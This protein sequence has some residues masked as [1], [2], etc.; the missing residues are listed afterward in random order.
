MAALALAACAPAAVPSP[1]LTPQPEAAPTTDV[2]RLTATPS[3]ASLPPAERPAGR[4]APA[5]PDAQVTP[6]P[7][8][9][10]ATPNPLAAWSI[11]AL[12]ARAYG[13]GDILVREDSP[14]L[15]PFHR[16]VIEYPSDGIT[17]T[18]LLEAPYGDG[19]FPVIVVLH[20]YIPVTEYRRGDDALAAADH[21]AMQ[22]YAVLI[23]D[24]RGYM[25]TAGGP[26]PLRIPYAVDALNLIESLDT[27][28][29]LDA[30]RVGVIG[31]SMGGGAAS[32]VMVL[33]ERVDAVV[34]YAPMSA[35]QALNY[36]YIAE[37]WS[38]YWMSLTAARYG[39]PESNPAGYAATS[40]IN[41]LDRVR[42][43]VQIHHGTADGEVPYA[44]SADLAARLEAAG[45]PVELFSYPGAGHT[46]NGEDWPR[47]LARV[48]A[49]F[50]ANVREDQP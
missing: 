46:F 19:P 7:V 28:D 29:V 13:E 37:E 20:G 16:Y 43:P 25:G 4:A 38:A 23:P 40:P 32:Y 41:A 12:A 6:S 27:L 21:F 31:H 17:V 45:A 1:S 22:G 39:S 42:A 33:S 18:G 30:D 9:P 14:E 15:L 35:D 50:A 2:A 34:L 11:P 10:T 5:D 24:Y 44:W 47:F 3:P 36:T 26:D 8:L 48:E 49:F